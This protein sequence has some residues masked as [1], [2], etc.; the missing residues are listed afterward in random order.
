MNET[1]SNPFRVAV[2]DVGT[3]SILLLLAEVADG[4]IR[5]IRQELA[6][7]RL[8]RN[9]RQTGWIES[10]SIQ[11]AVDS[12]N[13]MKAD[14]SGVPIIGVGTQ[15]FRIARNATETLDVLRRQTGIEIEVLSSTEEAE[16]SFRGA[17]GGLREKGRMT[18]VDIGGGSTEIVT[19][20]PDGIDSARSY[21][22]G[23]VTLTEEAFHDPL[24]IGDIEMAEMKIREA[25][26]D[27]TWF[28]TAEWIAV[29]GT[30]T[31][32]AALELGLSRYDADR[33][34]GVRLSKERIE[35]WI[36]R[37]A[38]LPLSL[39]R[40]M[41]PFDPERADIII[42]GSLII[43]EISRRLGDCIVSDRGLRFGIAHREYAKRR[44]T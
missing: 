31:T 17:L 40:G 18:V 13:R 15:V 20:A 10:E 34:H 44:K 37:L 14:L 27:A 26:R 28:E 25:L 9:I 41:I 21:S 4:R 8:G 30:A 11:R 35:H 32:L 42:A 12:I 33:V 2:L 22:I 6:S 24:S 39:R 38:V 1:Q 29:G 16:W 5:P 36:Q 23:A 19:G 7:P 43:K 3:N